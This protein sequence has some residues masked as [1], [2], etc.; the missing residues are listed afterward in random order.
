[1]GKREITEYVEVVE[2]EKVWLCD[3]CGRSDKFLDGSFE[4]VK[5]NTH[6]PNSENFNSQESE[7]NNIVFDGWY[8]PHLIEMSH[9]QELHL[10]N[11]CYNAYTEVL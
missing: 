5:I 2:E 1:M 10:C 9:K 8:P 4:D 7:G 11:E 3:F 6:L